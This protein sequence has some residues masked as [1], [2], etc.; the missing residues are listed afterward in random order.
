M[1]TVV[2]LA[3]AALLYRL[4]LTDEP[5]DAEFVDRL[6]DEGLLRLLH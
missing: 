6:I 2:E 1:D 4:M 5:L 3:G